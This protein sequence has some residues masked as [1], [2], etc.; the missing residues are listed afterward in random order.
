MSEGVNC[1]YSI[2]FKKF[3]ENVLL[4]STKMNTIRAK[5]RDAITLRAFL[6]VASEEKLIAMP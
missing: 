2:P 3:G 1:K 4:K 6:R 5:Y